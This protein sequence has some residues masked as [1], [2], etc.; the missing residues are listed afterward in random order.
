MIITSIEPRRKG[1]SAV[2]IDGEYAMQLDTFTLCERRV[3]PG[4]ELT[5]EQLHELIQK[6]E[7]HRAK[8]KALYLI[9]YRDHSKKELTDK[10]KRVCSLESAENAADKMEALGL[11]NDEAFA[12][13][14]AEEL[15]C[16]KKLSS[17]AAKYKLIQKGID[18]ELADQVIDELKPDPQE[19]LYA[20]LNGKFRLR[21][22]DEK[23]L[24]KTISALQRMGYRFED[25]KS[26][27]LRLTDED[28]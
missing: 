28:I 24:K 2:Y 26:A 8:E 6:S 17:S 13:R 14:Y 20:L 12:R 16:S 4:S 22:S 9:T 15:L 25:I 19:Q 27:L 23:N 3:K 10:I 1:M 11:I 5:D 7:A 21:L 18:R